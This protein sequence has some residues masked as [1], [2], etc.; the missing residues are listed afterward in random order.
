[1]NVKHQLCMLKTI[2]E[3]SFTAVD[4]TLYLDTHPDDPNALGHYNAISQQ[5]ECAKKAYE[6]IYGPLMPFGES[7][8]QFPWRWIRGPWPWEI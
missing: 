1:M 7:P 3:L 2:Q 6:E 5:L 8:S 4:L